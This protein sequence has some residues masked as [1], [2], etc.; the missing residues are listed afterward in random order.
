MGWSFEP[1]GAGVER[2]AN[3]RI[4]ETAY[5]PQGRIIALGHIHQERF[6]E[7]SVL[8]SS[9]GVE[10][11]NNLLEYFTLPYFELNLSGGALN[12]YLAK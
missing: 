4:V 2:L 5:T 7:L 1:L 8:E 12:G 3:R 11:I 6:F 9:N 10:L